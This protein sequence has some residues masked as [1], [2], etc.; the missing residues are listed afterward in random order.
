MNRTCQT[1]S[2]GEGVLFLEE[3]LAP[4][5]GRFKEAMSCPNIH[6]GPMDNKFIACF[7]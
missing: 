3:Q 5:V 6:Y 1:A 2:A 7:T 4:S